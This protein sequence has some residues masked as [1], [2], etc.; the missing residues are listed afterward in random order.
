MLALFVSLAITSCGGKTDNSASS[1]GKPNSSGSAAH[2]HT[3]DTSKWES[4]ATYHWHP[5]TC[6]HTTQKGD[7]ANHTLAD[8]SDATH[9]NKAATCKE[10]GVKFEKCSVCDYIK[11]TKLDKLEHQWDEGRITKE[12]TCSEPGEKTFTCSLCGDTKKEEVKADHTWGEATPVEGEASEAAYNIF[13]CTVCGVKKI[14][15]AGKQ[16]SGKSTLDGSLKSDSQFPDYIKLGT[17]GNSISYSFNYAGEA[18][19]KAHVYLRGVMDYWHDG[20]NENQARNFFSGKNSQDGN[21]ELK[22]NDVAVDYSWSKDITYE[23]ML[24]GEAQGSYSPLG[25][26]LVG[27][28]AVNNGANTLVFKRTESY[29]MLIKDFVIILG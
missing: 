23:D 9:G 2:V 29:N 15:I 7:R 20:N 3:F 16:A 26:A 13:T 12:A 28:C 1:G 25:D 21:F 6:E 24:P 14:E 5:A 8:F 22:I 19:A 4:D 17:N 27:E 18:V 10:D 11:E